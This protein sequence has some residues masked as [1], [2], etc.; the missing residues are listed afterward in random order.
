MMKEYTYAVV[1]IGELLADL[2]GAEPSASVGETSAFLRFQGGSPANLAANMA[3]LG[4][5]TAVVSCTGADSLGNYLVASVASSGVDVSFIVQ[6]PEVPSSLVLVSRTQ[7]TPDFIP[8]RTSDPR[9]L[10]QHLSDELLSQTGLIHTTC[11][12]LSLDPAQATVLDAA[13]RARAMGVR[14]SVDLNYTPKVWPN[15]AEAHEV[16]QS[17]VQG[18]GLVK[19]SE[20]DAERFWD[21]TLSPEMIRETL[22]GWGASLVCL[23]LGAAGSWVSSSAG[24]VHFVPATPIEVVDA[25]GAGDAYWSGFL[26]AYLAD[27]SLERCAQAGARMAA[28]KLTT[29]GPL[30]E[31][32]DKSLLWE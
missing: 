20:D 13:T 26:T 32:I 2:I 10:P 9:L 31:S 15:R 29:L 28:I 21:G 27:E 12:P 4:A 5:Q 16:I 22:H 1:A 25:T 30:K 3:R 7:G 6:D 14:C 18:G 24:E 17:Y 8:Y 19:L 11:W 23:T